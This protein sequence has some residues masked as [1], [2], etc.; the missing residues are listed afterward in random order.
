MYQTLNLVSVPSTVSRT[1]VL[2][3]T[4]MRRASFSGFVFGGTVTGDVAYVLIHL[5][6]CEPIP[7]NE[8]D[9]V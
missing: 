9:A 4:Q 5:V 1:T 6:C 3:S 7:N 2:L 8:D